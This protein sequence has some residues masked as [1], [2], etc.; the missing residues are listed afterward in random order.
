MKGKKPQTAPVGAVVPPWEATLSA[1]LSVLRQEIVDR[2]LDPDGTARW[3]W[4]PWPD[5][6]N[7]AMHTGAA[8]G[9]GKPPFLD[10]QRPLRMLEAQA[11]WAIGAEIHH[12]L[13]ILP[14]AVPGQIECRWHAANP[15][16]RMQP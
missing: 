4:D 9:Q 2:G 6:K 1:Q 5:R 7:A 15:R 11:W 8:A 10:P 13:L 14:G 12:H 16:E 3:V